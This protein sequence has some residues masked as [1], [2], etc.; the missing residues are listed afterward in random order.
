MSTPR[1]PS[2]AR[3][4]EIIPTEGNGIAVKWYRQGISGTT[5]FKP[6]DLAKRCPD[7]LAILPLFA[8]TYKQMLGSLAA[9]ASREEQKREKRQKA[10]IISV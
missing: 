4:T 9:M 1:I 6:V 2:G 8:L 10:E 5:Y 7:A 3:L